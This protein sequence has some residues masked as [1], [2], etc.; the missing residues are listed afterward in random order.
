M[1]AL[2][3]LAF[4]VAVVPAWLGLYNDYVQFLIVL[5]G[6]NIILTASL[7]LINGYMGEFSVGHAAFM[8]VGAYVAALI[9]VWLLAQDNVFGAPLLPAGFSLVVFPLALLIGG[10]AAAMF[11]LLVAIPSF[12][13]RGDYLA[14][15]TLAV[16]FIFKSVIEN[17]EAIGGPRGF[18]GMGGVISAMDEVVQAPWLVIWTFIATVT[19]LF[20]IRNFVS[21]TVGKGVV[22]IRD[23]EIAAEVMTINTRRLKVVVFMLGCGMAGVAGGLHGHLLGFINPSSYFILQSTLVLVMVYLGGM[24]SLSGSV[25]SAVGLTLLL[26]ALRPLGVVRWVLIPLFLIVIMRIRPSGIMGDRELSDVL[27][28]LLSRF[29][30]Q[31]PKE[32]A[33]EP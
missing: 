26:E 25:I 20:V 14:V 4:L 21:S 8:G 15:I 32:A 28:G 11:S 18:M 2:V 24:G 13:T 10:V 33:G 12:R 7:N 17:L 30:R 6:I 22:A 3:G 29:R 1:Q 31:P 5:I 19:T 16:V 9:T 23:D 27:P